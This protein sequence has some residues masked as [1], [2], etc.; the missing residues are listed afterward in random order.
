MGV[1]MNPK[2]T[3]TMHRK[4]LRDSVDLTDYSK[5]SGKTENRGLSLILAGLW[6]TISYFKPSWILVPKRCGSD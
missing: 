4:A 5:S 1:C 6:G 3:T 2:Y